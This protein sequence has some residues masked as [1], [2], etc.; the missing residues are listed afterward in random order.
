MVGGCAFAVNQNGERI[1][2]HDVN[3]LTVMASESY[4]GFVAGLQTEMEQDSSRK[5]GVVDKTDFAVITFPTPDGE[6]ENIT[7]GSLSNCGPHCAKRGT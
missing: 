7:R 4:E 1:Y 5:F 3:T 2:G 6:L